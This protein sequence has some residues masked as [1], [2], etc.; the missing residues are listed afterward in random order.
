MSLF[1][2]RQIVL[3]TVTAEDVTLLQGSPGREE[4]HDVFPVH[5]HAHLSK[6]PMLYGILLRSDN[7]ALKLIRSAGAFVVNF[8]SAEHTSKIQQASRVSIQFTNKVEELGFRATECEHLL[9]SF[10]LAEALGWIECQLHQEIPTG[11]ST[12][13]VGKVVH[14]EQVSEDTRPMFTG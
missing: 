11:D 7:P 13:V 14:I 1:D 3:I 8:V 5:R 10:R 6:N 4:Q 2:P 12:L 9:D